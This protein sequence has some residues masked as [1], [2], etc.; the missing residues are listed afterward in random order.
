[1][2]WDLKSAV[3]FRSWPTALVGI[4]SALGWVVLSLTPGQVASANGV[5]SAQTLETL[6]NSDVL[7]GILCEPDCGR[8]FE[9]GQEQF[10][11]EI[12]RLEERI[13]HVDEADALL[14][15]DPALQEQT[16]EWQQEFEQ[17]VQSR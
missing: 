6:R 1:M 7:N 15:I 17:E 11:V 8:F 9:A 3:F 10:E 13:S 16:E 12:Q 5:P 2:W 14:Q 4:G